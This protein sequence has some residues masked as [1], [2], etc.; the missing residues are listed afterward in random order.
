MIKFIKVFVDI[1]L[2]IKIL[3][4]KLINELLNAIIVWNFC[5]RW[6]SLQKL[7]PIPFLSR[8]LALN[9]TSSAYKSDFFSDRFKLSVN[10]CFK[11]ALINGITMGFCLDRNF[12]NIFC[13]VFNFNFSN[14]SCVS[15]IWNLH[16]TPCLEGLLFL[17]H[18]LLLRHQGDFMKSTRRR[19]PPMNGIFFLLA[20]V[21]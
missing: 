5:W 11:P 2:C 18:A 6:P 17:F 19:K 12:L 3:L 4:S 15:K 20:V 10:I 14:W 9:S 8:M 16:N 1:S 13:Q 21:L 7:P